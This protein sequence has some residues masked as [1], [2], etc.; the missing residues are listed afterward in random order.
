MLD[1]CRAREVEIGD[2]CRRFGCDCGK[3]FEFAFD[4]VLKSQWIEGIRSF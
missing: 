4:P 2:Q 1:V 3:C